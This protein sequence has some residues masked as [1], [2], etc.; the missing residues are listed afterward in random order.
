MKKRSKWTMALLF[1]RRKGLLCRKTK[2]NYAIRRRVS[3]VV[4]PHDGYTYDYNR[5][6]QHIHAEIRNLN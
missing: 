2:V 3:H 5:T 1:L 6:A 4:F